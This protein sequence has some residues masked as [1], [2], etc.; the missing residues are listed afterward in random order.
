M[1]EPSIGSAIFVQV[2]CNILVRNSKIPEI[3]LLTSTL[4]L[5]RKLKLPV[6]ARLV[7]R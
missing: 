4:S 1:A 3:P 7:N 2:Y 5:L 6:Y